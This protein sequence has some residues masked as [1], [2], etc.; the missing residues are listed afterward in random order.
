MIPQIAISLFICVSLF[1]FDLVFHGEPFS[2]ESFGASGLGG[3]GVLAAV[4]GLPKARS[5]WGRVSTF[6]T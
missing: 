4:R 1:M 2:G 6:H 3:A 5:A